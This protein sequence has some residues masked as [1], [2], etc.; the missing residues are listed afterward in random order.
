[1]IIAYRSEGEDYSD[2]EKE[3]P[4]DIFTLQFADKLNAIYV[5]DVSPRCCRPRRISCVDILDKSGKRRQCK[6]VLGRAVCDG[7]FEKY[8]CSALKNFVKDK[9]GKQAAEEEVIVDAPSNIITVSR[10]VDNQK[11]DESTGKAKGTMC[12]CIN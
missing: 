10:P 7:G 11:V 4:E 2:N 3:T 12:Y 6:S 8:T 1:M 9:I 5:E